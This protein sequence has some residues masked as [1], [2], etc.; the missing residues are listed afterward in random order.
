[1]APGTPP[2]S[3][4]E[5][6]ELR[7]RLQAYSRQISLIAEQIAALDAGSLGRFHELAVERHRIERELGDA[8]A[9]PFGD[10]PAAPEGLDDELAQ[11]LRDMQGRVE[12]DER[13]RDRLQGLQDAALH[14]TR[15]LEIRRPEGGEYMTAGRVPCQLDVRM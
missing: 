13:V 8:G 5:H 9:P 6:E 2:P 11:A 7:R 15:G 14:A 12:G 3:L 1:M 4:R 10:A